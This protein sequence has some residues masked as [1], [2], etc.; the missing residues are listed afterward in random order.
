M[1]RTKGKTKS[2]KSTSSVKEVD[3]YNHEGKKRKNI[4]QVGLVSSVTDKLNGRTKYQHDPH[5]DPC[6]GWAGKAEGL[7]FEVQNVSL[8]I[9]ERIDPK[10]VIKQFLKEEEQIQEKQLSLFQQPNNEPPL[11]RAIDFY[12]HDQDWTNRLIAGDSLLVMNSLLHKESMAGKVQMVYIDPPYGVKYN[13]NFQPFVNKKEVKDNKDEDLPTEPETI[14]AFR[15][16]WELGIHSYLQYL[17]DR[18]L[19]TKQLLTESGSC[20]VQ[21]SDENVHH[22]R[23]IMDEVFGTGNFISVIPFRKTVGATSNMLPTVNDYIVW[24]AKSKNMLKFNPL[25]TERANILDSKFSLYENEKGDLISLEGLDINKIKLDKLVA[26]DDLT[27][28]DPTKTGNFQIT[29][30]KKTYLPGSNRH[31]RTTKEGIDRLIELNRIIERGAK[32]LY[33]RYLGDFSLLPLNNFWF[34]TVNSFEKRIY[35]VQTTQLV[36]QRCLLMTTD[37]GD[38]ILDPTCGSGTTAYVAEQ[39]GRRWITC[40]SSRVA[41]TLAKQRLMT[42]R[43]DYYKLAYENEGIK[44]GFEYK[45]VPHITLRSIANNEPSQEEVLYDQPS[46][47]SK[48][49][50]VTGPFTAEAVPCLRTKPFSDANNHIETNGNQIAKLGET[51]NYK[52]WMDELKATGIRA[53]GNRLIKFSRIEPMPG[54]RFLHAEAEVLEDTGKTKKAIVSFGPD[55]G[56]LEQRQIE[57]ALNEVRDLKDKPDLVIFTAFHF[58]PEAAKDIDHIEIKGITVLKAQMSG[59][60]L[61][62]DLRKKRSSNQSFWLIGEPDIDITK[63]KDGAYK[64]KVNGFDYYNPISGE[65]EP[66]SSK[67]IA[68]WMLD[69]DYDERSI[70]PEQIFFPMQNEKLS[71]EKLAKSLNSQVDE[72]KLEAFKG[73]ESLPFKAGVNRKIAVKIIDDRGIESLVVKNLP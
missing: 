17:K 63:N 22:V 45:R 26:L 9:H 71:W 53:A 69:T 51:G 42:A 62:A 41:I 38:L 15:D 34:D 21:I 60:L 47:D 73:V 56:P 23:E 36:V 57:I 40:D 3:S 33:K 54:T 68:M 67:K 2:N 58:D 14:R 6:L 7:S 31:W 28:Q 8:H 44:S 10:R 61:T 5:I 4:P 25:F 32:I 39:W 66:G 43:F 11:N 49:T 70:F 30:N 65:L 46:S 18:L 55:F 59:D 27:S 52:E 37:P 29:F 12:S 48:K 20:F 72:E 50:R 13:S 1:P 35:V 16:T 64:V 24:Y 19:L